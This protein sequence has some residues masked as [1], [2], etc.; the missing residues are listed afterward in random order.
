MQS[1]RDR[2]PR[3][4]PGRGC[5]RS[6]HEEGV[7]D[8]RTDLF[9]RGVILTHMDA[10]GADRGGDSGVVVDK[11]R[12]PRPRGRW[13]GGI[14]PS[15]APRLRNVPSP[16][17]GSRR[18]PPR[19]S[20]RDADEGGRRGVAEIDDAVKSG[21]QKACCGAWQRRLNRVGSGSQPGS[22][23]AGTN[24]S[25]PVRERLTRMGEFEKISARLF[26]PPQPLRTMARSRS[27]N[28][29][30]PVWTCLRS[31]TSASSC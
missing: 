16:G 6:A 11:K 31:S 12:Q 2:R 15:G 23:H 9:H 10:V 26:V 5:G 24:S 13:G 7:A 4:R 30:V 21:V 20:R 3:R 22:V 14:R 28:R 1:V 8:D 29:N 19:S 27:P 17:A 18:C 25:P